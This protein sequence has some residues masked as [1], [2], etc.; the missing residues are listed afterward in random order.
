MIEVLMFVV[1]VELEEVFV[2]VVSMVEKVLV[3]AVLV[4]ELKMK[5]MM[6]VEKFD[7][8]DKK[9]FVVNIVVVVE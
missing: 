2:P 6:I 8:V 1:V 4:A 9:M 5:Y 3:V 7:L